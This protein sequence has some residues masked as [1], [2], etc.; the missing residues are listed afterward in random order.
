[1]ELDLDELKTIHIHPKYEVD[2]VLP[3]APKL[4][5]K[6]SMH[7]AAV[8]FMAVGCSHRRS[9][10]FL[11]DVL[12][13]WKKWRKHPC[14][15]AVELEVLLWDNCNDKALKSPWRPAPIRPLRIITNHVESEESWKER[16][17]AT[18]AEWL[19]LMQELCD[20]MNGTRACE[21][22]VL[23]PIVPQNN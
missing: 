23:A 11:N 5:T 3:K 20:A 22:V 8:L 14:K 6:P 12:R 7:S 19:R 4:F 10:E 16:G 13:V 18:R 15:T 17:A 21:I 2:F 9:T 1:M